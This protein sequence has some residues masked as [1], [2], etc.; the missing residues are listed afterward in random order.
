M[1]GFSAKTITGARSTIYSQRGN[2]QANKDWSEPASWIPAY[3]EGE[4]ARFARHLWEGSGH[5]I[6]PRHFLGHWLLARRYA[7]I[8]EGAGGVLQITERGRTFLSDPNGAVVR[9]VDDREGVFKALSLVAENGPARKGA[10]FDPWRIYLAEVSNA[11][12]D[13]YANSTL[14]DRLKNLRARGYVE[15][16]R[17]AYSITSDGLAWLDHS[18]ESEAA[19]GGDAYQQILN[20][21]RSQ[22]QEISDTLHELLHEMDPYAFEHMV[23]QLLDNMGYDNPRVTPRGNDKGV[24]VV[25]SIEM[26]IT[27]IQEVIQVKRQRNNIQRPVLDALRGSLHRFRADRGTIITTSGFSKGTV[28]AAIELGA[29]PITLIDGHKL[30]ELLIEHG[31]GV[32][33]KPIEIWELDASAFDAES[34][35]ADEG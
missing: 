26:G 20:L 2:P 29:A 12:S 18:D 23:A 14:Y 19:P 30:V 5:T 35:E 28:D 24:D 17:A 13:S 16:S 6:N 1:E 21:A 3:L 10:L 32:K 7:L 33:K 8:S 15:L 11:R 9:E 4:Q 31:I 22:K 25:A 27:T 34:E